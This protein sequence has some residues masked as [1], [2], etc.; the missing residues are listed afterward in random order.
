MLSQPVVNLEGRTG[1]SLNGK[2]HYIVDPYETG[3]KK[4]AF[5]ILRKFYLQKE[6]EWNE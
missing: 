1:L 5:Y 6:M 4:K 2:W 3:D